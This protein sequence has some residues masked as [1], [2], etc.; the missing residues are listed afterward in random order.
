MC[1]TI[2]VVDEVNDFITAMVPGEL[3][4]YLSA[5]KIAPCSEQIP[6]IEE[7]YPVEFLNSIVVH[8]YPHH[9]LKLKVGVPVVL[10]RNLNQS[11]G[12]CN[13]TRLLIT[14]LGD[15]VFEGTGLTSFSVGQSMCVPCI[16]LNATCPKWPF[17]M[18]RRQ[19]PVRV[20]YAMTIN[21][22]Q[23]QTLGRVGIYLRNP[24]FTHGQLYVAVSRVK[25]PV[26]LRVL[27]EEDDGSCSCMTKNFVYKEV[28]ATVGQ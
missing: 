28:L 5:D 7:L 1:P 20:C 14:K 15:Y 8:N 24:V 10:L 6:D 16:V 2:S 21:K 3:R 17:V 18:Q 25:S 23:G 27:I 12:L 19:F 4:E 26:R 11:Q 13:G 9:C 22:S